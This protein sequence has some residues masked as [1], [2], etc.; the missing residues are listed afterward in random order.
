MSDELNE[1]VIGDEPKNSEVSENKNTSNP[2]EVVITEEAVNQSVKT[3]QEVM[4]DQERRNSKTQML[5]EAL[6]DHMAPFI[7]DMELDTKNKSYGASFQDK[8]MLLANFTALLN[9][10]DNSD[11][12]MVSSRLKLK[13]IETNSKRNETNA[14]EFLSQMR[15]LINEGKGLNNIE[16]TQPTAEEIDSKMDEVT[17]SNDLKILDTELSMGGTMLPKEGAP[18]PKLI[19]DLDDDKKDKDE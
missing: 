7:L 17:E 3:I 18:A 2:N 14:A 1:L 15:K 10:I 13:D 19:I 8:S 4:F 5:R 12:N 11:K 6:V 16:I 9:D